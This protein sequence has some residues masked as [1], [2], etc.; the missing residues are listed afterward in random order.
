MHKPGASIAG[1]VPI[2]IPSALSLLFMAKL[3]L[4]LAWAM[5]QEASLERLIVRTDGTY[6]AHWKV[7]CRSNLPCEVRLP[8]RFTYLSASSRT[9]VIAL[10]MEAD[11]LW[12]PFSANLPNESGIPLGLSVTATYLAGSDPEEIKGILQEYTRNYIV[13]ST[14]QGTHWISRQYLISLYFEAQ[15]GGASAYPATR[16]QISP[17]NSSVDS[18][19]LIT[20]GNLVDSLRFFYFIEPLERDSYRLTA[21]VRIPPMWGKAYETNL[22]VQAQDNFIRSIGRFR[23]PAYA[24]FQVRLAEYTLR[25]R[26]IY[27]F[28]LPPKIFP[29]DSGMMVVEA[30]SILHLFSEEAFHLPPGESYIR[31]R[32][33]TCMAFFSDIGPSLRIPYPDPVPLRATLHEVPQKLDRKASPT[34]VGTLRVTNPFSES[35]SLRVE[36]PVP[37]ECRLSETGLARVERRDS[38][39][40]L[41]WEVVLAPGQ[42]INFSYRYAKP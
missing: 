1:V 26:E 25:G 14:T 4:F 11:T 32:S 22:E 7:S 33:G 31:F 41:S 29:A 34:T 9:P 27:L 35:I 38:L 15:A 37:G 21:W 12:G 28:S 36:K 39:Y 8:G 30:R 40:L 2:P 13:I 5:A 42:N 19:F 3:W 24:E 18:V 23:W 20:R 17:Q 10:T 6:E 16:L